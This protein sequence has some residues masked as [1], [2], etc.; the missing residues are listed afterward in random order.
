MV[1]QGMPPGRIATD[2]LAT[3]FAR[4]RANPSRP[5]QP[6]RRPS[7][8][9][10]QGIVFPPWRR[11]ENGST[12]AARRRQ[13]GERHGLSSAAA[14]TSGASSPPRRSSP[15]IIA[16]RFAIGGWRFQDQL[17]ESEKS[18]A[19]SGLLGK[20]NQVEI[21]TSAA[22]AVSRGRTT[23]R[24]QR[25]GGI[26]WQE[27]LL[28]GLRFSAWFFLQ[29]S[30]ITSQRV[31]RSMPR[32]DNRLLRRVGCKRYSHVTCVARLQTRNSSHRNNPIEHRN[33]LPGRSAS[34]VT[35]S[36]FTNNAGDWP[37]F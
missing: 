16:K 14:W 4:R 34:G 29:A 8:R 10:R 26:S 15:P 13:S 37:A 28:K 6:R 36:I 5:G 31:R 24:R 21:G 18:P 1:R 35:K 33:P 22:S 19:G 17:P 23:T 3:G 30:A 9:D 11:R 20:R 27:S 7:G 12:A 2:E 32:S 25:G